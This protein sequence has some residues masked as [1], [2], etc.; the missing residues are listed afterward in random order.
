MLPVS[1]A[2]TPAPTPVPA[3][4]GRP[5][6]PPE[7]GDEATASE[8]AL[9]RLAAE[10]T[11]QF[12][13]LKLG[14]SEAFPNREL[15][16]EHLLRIKTE[17]SLQESTKAAATAYYAVAGPY[18]Q[19][20]T[21]KCVCGQCQP[22]LIKAALRPLRDALVL[23]CLA[24][25]GHR[26]R[27]AF[28]Q[29]LESVSEGHWSTTVESQLLNAFG[30]LVLAAKLPDA[31]RS[32]NVQVKRPSKKWKTVM[33]SALG[34]VGAVASDAVASDAVAAD[35][36]GASA[37]SLP[38][39]ASGTA[40]ADLNQPSSGFSKACRRGHVPTPP[41]TC[42]EG[43]GLRP[44]SIV[45]DQHM[46]LTCGFVPVDLDCEDSWKVQIDGLLSQM[47]PEYSGP[48]LCSSCAAALDAR[49]AELPLVPLWSRAGA[50]LTRRVLSV[51]SCVMLRL[52][53]DDT[54]QSACAAALLRLLR[55][56]GDG[57]ALQLSVVPGDP[58]S[59]MVSEQDSVAGK[60][61]LDAVLAGKKGWPWRV[62]PTRLRLLALTQKFSA[63]L[64]VV[65]DDAVVF[66][67][68]LDHLHDS[69][70]WCLVRCLPCAGSWKGPWHERARN[71]ARSIAQQQAVPSDTVVLDMEFWALERWVNEAMRHGMMP[72]HSELQTRCL[73]ACLLFGVERVIFG[74]L[75]DS[76][77]HRWL[78]AAL[79]VVLALHGME[80][81]G[82]EEAQNIVGLLLDWRRDERAQRLFE[83]DMAASKECDLQCEYMHTLGSLLRGQSF[84]V[85]DLARPRGEAERVRSAL[86]AI[87]YTGL[88]GQRA[89]VP[90]EGRKATAAASRAAVDL[91][92]LGTTSQDIWAFEIRRLHD[93]AAW[94]Q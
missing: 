41:R 68:I 80:L 20:D 2:P 29:M 7:E 22:C 32:H 87:L 16:R 77:D 6:S 36:P 14:V 54:V 49:F 79:R 88:R 25:V 17:P 39:G 76:V 86:D 51:L 72:D 1:C 18:L 89:G 92:F 13:V 58:P 43:I 33:S 12:A 15:A 5:A 57:L 61:L 38:A 60:M 9:F 48:T 75:R 11:R 74:S 53:D 10:Q 46:Y 45:H 27:K 69:F 78:L 90:P 81:L 24:L 84:A 56:R 34:C 71:F 94:H 37:P 26:N 42:V 82:A 44:F 65:H 8:R 21:G 50:E 3:V 52:H 64:A 28:I 85:S 70:F 91:L 73:L 19:D 30:Q 55:R 67:D 35:A 47:M 93:R 63:L 23:Y 31:F 83:A 59:F 40:A 62:L 4:D 66:E